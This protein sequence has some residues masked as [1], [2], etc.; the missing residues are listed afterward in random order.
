MQKFFRC[1]CETAMPKTVTKKKE[2]RRNAMV[3]RTDVGSISKWKNYST[4]YI[5]TECVIRVQQKLKEKCTCVAARSCENKIRAFVSLFSLVFFF[6]IFFLLIFIAAAAG[7][8]YA[9]IL[10][11]HNHM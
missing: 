5:H 4:R 2:Q 9:V 6:R 10:C 3:I 11:A 8:Y 7:R 1:Q